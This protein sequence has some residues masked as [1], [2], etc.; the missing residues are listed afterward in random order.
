MSI[1]FKA[2][3]KP[4]QIVTLLVGVPGSGKSTVCEQLDHIYTYVPHDDY[5]GNSSGHKETILRAAI[6]GDKPVL[7]ETPF[8]ISDMKDP[9]ESCGLTVRT[10]FI[11]EDPKVLAARYKDREGKEI[12]KGH[13]TRQETYRKRAEES[14]SFAG[15]AKDVLEY[16][17]HR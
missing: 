14:N 17:A 10:V 4:P 9:L 15:T 3:K 7:T 6:N 12:P 1:K 8:S 2:L 5:K 16:L 13:L 11:L